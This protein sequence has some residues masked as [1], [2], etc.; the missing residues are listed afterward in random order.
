MVAFQIEIMSVLVIAKT[1][2]TFPHTAERLGDF[3][4]RTAAGLKGPLPVAVWD[5]RAKGA[6]PEAFR[7]SLRPTPEAF[8][9]LVRFAMSCAAPNADATTGALENT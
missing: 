6:G 1:G 2:S 8:G 7:A 5:A 3:E 9:R 4:D